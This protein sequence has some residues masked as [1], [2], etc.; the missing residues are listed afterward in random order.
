MFK[1]YKSYKNY[2]VVD[3]LF[4]ILFF[5]LSV[6]TSHI[7]YVTLTCISAILFYYDYKKNLRGL[8]NGT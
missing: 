1:N 2:M 4:I 5:I 3:I 6:M 7:I 8:T